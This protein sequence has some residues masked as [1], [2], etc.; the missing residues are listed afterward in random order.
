MGF[1]LTRSY[2]SHSMEG[3]KYLRKLNKFYAYSIQTTRFTDD[4]LLNKC[5]SNEFKVNAIENNWIHPYEI[6]F[7]AMIEFNEGS[8]PPTQT[9]WIRS[10]DRSIES[11]LLIAVYV[12]VS[13][14]CVRFFFQVIWKSTILQLVAFKPNDA[15]RVQSIVNVSVKTRRSWMERGNV[16]YSVEIKLKK[17]RIHS[18][19]M[20]QQHQ[21]AYQVSMCKITND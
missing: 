17:R 4:Y 13:S 12:F 15:S 16:E 6:S 7:I 9:W 19:R 1:R 21:L 8:S 2:S 18:D 5:Q 11:E 20:E 10:I 3:Q 14:V